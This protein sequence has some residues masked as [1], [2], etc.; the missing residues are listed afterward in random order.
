[1][2]EIERRLAVRSGC[3]HAG[4]VTLRRSGKDF[5]DGDLH[6]LHKGFRAV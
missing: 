6:T 3:V 1:M 4:D 5:N 2:M